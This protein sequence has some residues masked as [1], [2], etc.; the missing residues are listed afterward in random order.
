MITSKVKENMKDIR[1]N[2]LKILSY[3][4]LH[5]MLGVTGAGAHLFSYFFVDPKLLNIIS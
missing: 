1:G 4:Q 2:K 3:T 5:Y